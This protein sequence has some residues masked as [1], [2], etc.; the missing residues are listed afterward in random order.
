[1]KKELDK[2]R[3][4]DEKAVPGYQFYWIS[5]HVKSTLNNITILF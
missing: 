2:L 3:Y 4:E 5:K 1:M